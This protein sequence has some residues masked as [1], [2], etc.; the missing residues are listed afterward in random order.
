M[1]KNHLFGFMLILVVLVS[2]SSRAWCDPCEFVP[3]NVLWN[4][5]SDKTLQVGQNFNY[6]INH[7][8]CFDGAYCS[9]DYYFT[10][11]S[12]PAGMYLQDPATIRWTPTD[13][14]IGIHNVQVKLTVEFYSPYP[15]VRHTYKDFDITVTDCT[16]SKVGINSEVW[17]QGDAMRVRVT[18]NNNSACSDSVYWYVTVDPDHGNDWR[19]GN[20]NINPGASVVVVDL[21]YHGFNDGVCHGTYAEIAPSRPNEYKTKK[22]R[23]FPDGCGYYD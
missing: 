17:A 7:D 16:K 21:T 5:I 23:D 13:A 15:R 18:L 8:A 14:Q 2:F 12:A 11:V 20:V 10:L 1:N 22:Y 4:N 9:Y 3:C 6:W 19:E